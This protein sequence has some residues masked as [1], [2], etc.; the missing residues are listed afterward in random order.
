MLKISDYL[1]M[2]FVERL[3]GVFHLRKYD[4]IHHS[5]LVAILFERFAKMEGIPITSDSLSAV[6]HHDV[7]ETVTGDLSYVVKNY[8]KTTKNSWEKIEHQMLDKESRFCDFTD[9]KMKEVL[10]E[11]QFRLFKSCDLFELWIYIVNEYCLGN[12]HSD[13]IEIKDRCR[14]IIEGYGFSSVINE[15]NEFEKEMI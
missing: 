5:F 7:F 4:L 14:E 2:G 15:M 11:E 12:H 6:M 9:E 1:R 3:S 13:I 8:N 10:S